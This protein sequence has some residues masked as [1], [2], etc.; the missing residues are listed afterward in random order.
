MVSVGDGPWDATT[1][2]E[3]G[4]DF[5]GVGHEGH[6]RRLIELGARAVVRDFADLPRFMD[7]LEIV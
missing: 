6:A 5:I 3:L 1:A 2:A 7:A 4:M